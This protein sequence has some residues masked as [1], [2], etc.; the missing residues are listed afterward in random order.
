MKPLRMTEV[1][2]KRVDVSDIAALIQRL[3]PDQG[4]IEVQRDVPGRE[5]GWHMHEVDETIVVI[6]GELRFYWDDGE[7]LCG[8][9][10]VVSLPAKTRHGSIAQDRGATYLIAFQ[11]VRI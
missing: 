7:Q 9:G 2:S 8:P 1:H 3:L 11:P 4:C 5:H 6:D 10:D